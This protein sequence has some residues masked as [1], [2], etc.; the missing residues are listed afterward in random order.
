MSK[1]SKA[2]GPDKLSPVMLKHLGSK[3]LNFLTKI[4]NMVVNTANMPDEG[5]KYRP[6]SLLSQ[7]PSCWKVL[8]SPLSASVVPLADHQQEF[9]MTRS[10][11]TALQEI[12]EHITD[13][14]NRK[15]LA[16]RTLAVAINSN[17]TVTPK[18]HHRLPPG[19]KIRRPSSSPLRQTI[20]P[21]STT[22]VQYGLQT[23][24]THTGTVLSKHCTKDCHRLRKDV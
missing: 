9:T 20:N 7:L 4:F 10:T 15:K 24:A 1:S 22:V 18:I 3:G 6:V 17:S 14:L 2:L 8:Y 19:G 21:S 23:L 11:T 16:H 12:S 5:S 13:G